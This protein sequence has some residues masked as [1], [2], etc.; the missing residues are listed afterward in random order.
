MIGVVLHLFGL[1]R[2]IYIESGCG[3]IGVVLHLLRLFRYI[4]ILNQVVE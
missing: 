3:M 4:Y 2:K 1:S